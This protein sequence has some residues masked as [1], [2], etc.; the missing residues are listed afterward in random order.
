MGVKK[1]E[2]TMY[3]SANVFGPE[4]SGRVGSKT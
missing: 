1:M 3:S 2:T 4:C